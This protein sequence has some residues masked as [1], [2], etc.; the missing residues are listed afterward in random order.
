MDRRIGAQ[1][2]TVRNSIKTIEDF[3][4][5]CKKIKEIGYQIIQIS[6]TPLGA[7]E[8]KEVLDK[9]DLKVVVTHR[10]F[11]DFKNDLEEIITYNQTLGCDIC[12][13]GGMPMEVRTDKEKLDEFIEDANRIAK[14]LRGRGLYFGY[15]TH[16]FEFGKLEGE[17]IIDRLIEET[18]PEAF[19]F[20]CDVYWAQ[21]GGVNPAAFVKR[22]GKRARAVHFKDLAISLHEGYKTLTSA[23]GEGNLCWD[24]IIE[25][26]D[27]AGT[28]WALVEQDI[29]D[30]DPFDCL[31]SSYEYLKTKG[32]C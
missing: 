6:G 13:I 12:G 14:E 29:C 19:T 15:H 1:F 27:E 24:D 22:L 25:A 23:I 18:D 5:T 30:R 21:V 4:E 10:K 32:F 3:D 31:K 9:Y 2:Y 26:C 17:R 11:D 16:H 8:M 28:K 20:I 7:S